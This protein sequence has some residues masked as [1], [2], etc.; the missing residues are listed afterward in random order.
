MQECQQGVNPTN[1]E[2]SLAKEH[3]PWWQGSVPPM[4]EDPGHSPTNSKCVFSL[5]T[6]QR[7]ILPYVCY[8][9]STGQWPNVILQCIQSRRGQI[10]GWGSGP[11]L[12][13]QYYNVFNWGQIYHWGSGPMLPVQC[14]LS[15][16]GQSP[17]SVIPWKLRKSSV[18]WNFSYPEESKDPKESVKCL[19]IFFVPIPWD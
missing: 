15:K 3:E 1:W 11:M 18:L 19:V 2:A 12:W 10:Y 7:W 17:T 13:V 6:L 14:V 5:H 9:I 8:I 4:R 16:G